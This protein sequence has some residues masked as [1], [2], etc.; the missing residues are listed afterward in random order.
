MVA[1]SA[2]ALG[3]ASMVNNK[4]NRAPKKLHEDVKKVSA[5]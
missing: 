3:E 5:T 4:K 2:L 1:C